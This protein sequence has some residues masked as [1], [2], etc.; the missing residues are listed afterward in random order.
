MQNVPILGQSVGTTEPGPKCQR[1]GG[2]MPPLTDEMKSLMRSHAIELTHSEC[3]TDS[4]VPTD[5]LFE[6]QV[7]IVEV[8]PDPGIEDEDRTYDVELA[9][10]SAQER[11]DSLEDVMRP[12]AAALGER[13]MDVEK[14]ARIADADAAE[15]H[16][17]RQL[18]DQ[19]ADA[20]TQNAHRQD[21]DQ[22]LLAAREEVRDL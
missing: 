14:H 3:P 16:A 9:S 5:R 2:A 18:D 15:R 20:R 22:H 7:R 17:A 19:Q 10:F 4:A 11:A 8:I 21:V 13:W 1:C 12:L 6:V